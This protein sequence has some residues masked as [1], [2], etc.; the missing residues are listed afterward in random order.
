MHVKTF[1]CGCECCIYTKCMLSSLLAWRYHYLKK[2]KENG[3][4]SQNITSSEIKG[5]IIE[6]YKLCDAAC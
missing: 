4:N 2:L 1:M 3:F 5:P 6:T